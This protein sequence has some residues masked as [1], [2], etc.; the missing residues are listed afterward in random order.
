MITRQ[1][2]EKAAQEEAQNLAILNPS[3]RKLKQLLRAGSTHVL[4]SDKNRIDQREKV[5][6]LTIRKSASSIWFTYSV[7]KGH[8]PV[9]QVFIG[10]NIDLDNFN[11]SD[12]DIMS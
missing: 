9:V 8:D 5:W 4:G 6:G 11:L 7:N 1:D 10:E 2:I 3:V 12:V